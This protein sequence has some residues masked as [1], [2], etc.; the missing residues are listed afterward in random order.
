MA[1]PLRIE[2]GWF[3]HVTSRG[4]QRDNIYFSDEDR[5]KWLEL[6]GDVCKRF[7]WRCHAW[8]QMS[9]HYHLVVE[10]P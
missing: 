5:L 7:K 3:Y 4:D 8:Y 2:L 1:R 9:S 10:T 6:L